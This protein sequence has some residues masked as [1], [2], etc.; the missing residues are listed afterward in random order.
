MKVL[1]ARFRRDSLPAHTEQARFLQSE[2]GNRTQSDN[3]YGL[4]LA[5]IGSF[6]GETEPRKVTH[7]QA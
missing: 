5:L 2:A 6:H 7:T 1:P 4:T 3:R